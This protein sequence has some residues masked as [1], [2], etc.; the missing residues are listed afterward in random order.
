MTVI[1]NRQRNMC[2]TVTHSPYESGTPSAHETTHALFSH[3]RREAL[4]SDKSARLDDCLGTL[5]ATLEELR[6]SS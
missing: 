4:Y 1:T 2:H 5:F 3:C 6:G